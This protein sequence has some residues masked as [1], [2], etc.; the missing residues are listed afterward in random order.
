MENKKVNCMFEGKNIKGRKEKKKMSLNFNSLF[1]FVY[2]YIFYLYAPFLHKDWY[3]N[4]IKY[5]HLRFFL[6]KINNKT[7]LEF[8]FK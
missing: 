5:H 1:L 6:N 3:P 8:Y 4:H 2:I 7:Q